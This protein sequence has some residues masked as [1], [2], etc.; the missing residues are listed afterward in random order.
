MNKA[1]HMRFTRLLPLL[2]MFLLLGCDPDPVPQPTGSGASGITAIVNG[3]EWA[4]SEGRFSVGTR[5]VT[6]GASAFVGTGDTLT[7]I[8]VQVQGTDTT[9][10][11]LSVKLN[12]KKAGSYPIRSKSS[13]QGTAYF[14]PAGISASAL[15]QTRQSYATG[16][17]NGELII[18]TYDSV[19][20][21]VSG[22]FGFSMSADGNTTYT[23]VAGKIQNI[24]F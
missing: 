6:N 19:N 22:N 16:I 18:S 7:V 10:I 13:G 8:G 11:R 9:A 17:T 24:T 3:A 2:G 23:I 14:Y 15:Q 12:A 21:S 5:T 20:Y 1:K 4:S